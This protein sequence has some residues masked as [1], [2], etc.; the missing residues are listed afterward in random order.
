MG[1]DPRNF[2]FE[3]DEVKLTLAEPIEELTPTNDG[4]LVKTAHSVT[5]IK[6]IDGDDPMGLN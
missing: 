6:N 5:L 4:L 3:Q 1:F 2:D